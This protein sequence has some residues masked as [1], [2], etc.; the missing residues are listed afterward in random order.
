MFEVM[1]LKDVKNAFMEIP[2]E[3]LLGEFEN[4]PYVLN[5]GVHHV[6]G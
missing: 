6:Q 2:R 3:V 4:L 1:R 5:S